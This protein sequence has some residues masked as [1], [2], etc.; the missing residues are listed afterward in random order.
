MAC[1]GTPVAPATVDGSMY[2]GR[3]RIPDDPAIKAED[4]C[5]AEALDAAGRVL[6]RGHW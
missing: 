1:P 2:Y 4:V 6:G 5:A 3:I